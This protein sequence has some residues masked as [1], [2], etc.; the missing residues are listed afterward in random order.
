MRIRSIKPEFWRSDDIAAL[1]ISARLLFVGLWSYVDDNGV[2]SDKLPSI[3]ADL[4]ANDLVSDTAET[5]RRVNADLTQIQNAGLIVRFESEGK[6]LLYVTNWKKHQ[7]VRNPSQGNKYPLPPGVLL[8][9]NSADADSDQEPCA[10][11]T[12]TLRRPSALEGEGEGEGEQGNGGTEEQGSG[13]SPT[14]TCRKHSHWRHDEAC[15]SCLKDRQRFEAWEAAEASKP[16]PNVQH[17]HRWLGDGSCVGCTE[18]RDA[19]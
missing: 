14:P 3:V 4:F 12:Q 16:K 7:L 10:D 11:S 17:V 15:R 5:L 18:M 19:A 13:G 6:P 2:G 9:E 1:P 8:S